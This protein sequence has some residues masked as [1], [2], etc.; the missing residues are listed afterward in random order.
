MYEISCVDL[1]PLHVRATR[2]GMLIDVECLGA[3]VKTKKTCERVVR[4]K[5]L[6]AAAEFS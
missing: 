3:I 2:A 6:R 1:T 5:F 4:C